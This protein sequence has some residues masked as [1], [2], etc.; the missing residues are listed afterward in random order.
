MIRVNKS[1]L[2]NGI[3]GEIIRMLTISEIKGLTYLSM[4]ILVNVL[5]KA[6]TI[7]WHCN[8]K[9]LK[10]GSYLYDY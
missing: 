7:N 6:G 9:I 4:K 8:L 1:L 10:D 3:L 2:K 5:T